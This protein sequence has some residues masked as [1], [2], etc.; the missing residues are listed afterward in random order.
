MSKY[1]YTTVA[2][3]TLAASAG[4]WLLITWL[5]KEKR[6]LTPFLDRPAYSDRLDRVMHD[7]LA[8]HRFSIPWIAVRGSDGSLWFT[9][10]RF[11]SAH[12]FDRIKVQVTPDE[13]VTASITPY[14]FGPSDWAILG[15]SFVDFRPEAELIAKELASKL[16]D[17]KDKGR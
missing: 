9:T 11:Q 3:A 7:A 4:L 17:N 1:R 12:R 10:E 6:E 2:I 15:K 8:N 14:Q 13:H 5:P 16:N